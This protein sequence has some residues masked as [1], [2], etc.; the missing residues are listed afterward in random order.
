MLLNFTGPRFFFSCCISLTDSHCVV[1]QGSVMIP[2]DVG[3]V[4][5]TGFICVPLCFTA[6]SAFKQNYDCTYVPDIYFPVKNTGQTYIWPYF[7][8]KDTANSTFVDPN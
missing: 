1:H 6:T 3:R 5:F 4:I 7:R 8:N 2:I